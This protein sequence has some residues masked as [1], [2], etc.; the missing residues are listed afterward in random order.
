MS[1]TKIK[2]FIRNT[3]RIILA[4]ILLAIVFTAMA[5]KTT[6]VFCTLAFASV[7]I[8]LFGN[9][10]DVYNGENAVRHEG[11]RRC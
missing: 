2:V 6:P 4:S 10:E 5:V 11:R 8:Q 9:D 7:D 3:N 1:T